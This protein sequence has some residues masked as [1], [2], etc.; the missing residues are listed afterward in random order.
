MAYNRQKIED[1]AVKVIKKENLTFFTDLQIYLEPSL[2]TLYEWELEKSEEIKKALAVNRLSVKKKMRINWQDSDNPTL[3][4]A[5]Y[6]L[7]ADDEE[8]VK[9]TSNKHEISGDKGGPIKTENK[10]IVE[11]H[12]FTNGDQAGI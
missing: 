7:L 2:S 1:E 12:D 3:Q 6:K 4:V 10:H 9:L 5:A 8:L 11:F